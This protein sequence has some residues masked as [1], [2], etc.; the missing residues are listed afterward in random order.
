[1]RSKLVALFAGLA[2]GA[3]LFVGL[4]GAQADAPPPIGA[5][6]HFKIAASGEKVY[7]GPN[8]C[9]VSASDQGFYGYHYKVHAKDPGINDIL[10]EGC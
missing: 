8:F 9:D 2:M 7:V 3:S 6:R 10:S 4:G 5:H 1:M